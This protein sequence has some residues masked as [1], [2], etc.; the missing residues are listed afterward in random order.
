MARLQISCIT[1]TGMDSPVE[2]ISHIS[3]FSSGTRWTHSVDDA[4][5]RLEHGVNTYYIRFGVLEANVILAKHNR[6]KYLKTDSDTPQTD[7]LMSLPV[8][9]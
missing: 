1:K 8:C 6:N 9:P 7:Y 4:I 2:R 5:S 3:G